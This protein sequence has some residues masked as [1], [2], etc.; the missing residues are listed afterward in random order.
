MRNAMMVCA[1]LLSAA[2]AF[3]RTP[4]VPPSPLPGLGGSTRAWLN[5]QTNAAAQAPDVRAV[6][7]EVAEEVYQ[8]YVTSFKHPIPEQF[9]RE[10]FAQGGSGGGK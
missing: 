2:P 8:R 10:S 4:D 9:P 6:P 3:A 1:C 5:L 7:G